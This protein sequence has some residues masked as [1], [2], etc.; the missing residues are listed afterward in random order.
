MLPMRYVG[1][2]KQFVGLLRS[3]L[4]HRRCCRSLPLYCLVAIMIAAAQSS[5]AQVLSPPPQLQPT[6]EALEQ[7]HNCGKAIAH[8]APKISSNILDSQEQLFYGLA[9]GGYANGSNAGRGYN[10]SGGN[11]QGGGEWLAV[12]PPKDY[13]A[14]LAH[15]ARWCLQVANILNTDP[16]KKESAEK[17]LASIAEDLQ[18]KVKDCRD[19]GAGRLI[20]VIASTVKN[21]QPDPGWTVMYK[22]VSVSGLSST[23]LAFPQIST[24]TSKGLP[25]GVY[26]M[27]ATKQ[28]GDTVKKTPPITVSAFQDQK[29]KC[30]IPVP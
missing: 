15:E 3:A 16:E 26:A 6:V 28:V 4:A 30:E 13:V 17:V 10:R 11:S 23:D 14:D 29:V 2:G 1:R 18:V 12:P 21:G 9:K 20:T 25:P 22:W 7:L 27:Y 8:S 19:W 5:R 24:P